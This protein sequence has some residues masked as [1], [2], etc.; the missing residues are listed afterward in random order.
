[1]PRGVCQGSALGP[2]LFSLYINSVGSC[3]TS[4]FLLYT[5]DLVLPDS[6]TDESV[7]INNLSLQIEKLCDWCERNGVNVNFDQKNFMV[8]IGNEM[9]PP[10]LTLAKSLFET[11]V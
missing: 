5:D 11:N 9:E 10:L 6:G 7:I 1:M 4:P 3:F 8:S 2:L